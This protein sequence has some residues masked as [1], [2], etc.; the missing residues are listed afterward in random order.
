[1]TNKSLAAHN[2]R[3]L[4]LRNQQQFDELLKS[5]EPPLKANVVKTLLFDSFKETQEQL[6][7]TLKRVESTPTPARAPAGSKQEATPSP[8]AS[9]TRP[10]PTPTPLEETSPP[11]QG[12]HT[13]PPS[14]D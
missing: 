14:S 2:I 6:A 1:M 7:A 8:E 10:E 3:D 12:A 9:S 11:P 13:P 5:I 4:L